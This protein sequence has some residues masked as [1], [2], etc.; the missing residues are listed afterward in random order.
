VDPESPQIATANA[1]RCA[2]CD[3]DFSRHHV[4]RIPPV[5]DETHEGA[6]EF[7]AQRTPMRPVTH[8]ASGHRLGKYELLE[9]IGQ[10]GMAEVWLGRCSVEHGSKTC[11]I[12]V[13][14][15]HIAY[16]TRYRQM[17][18]NEAR[19]CMK[20]TNANIV[21]VFDA[22]QHDTAL[23]L[24]MEWVDG[25]D[26]CS[27]LGMAR[28]LGC[29]VPLSVVGH[30]VGEL[31]HA[32]DYAH[33]L[34]SGGIPLGIVHRDVSPHNVMISTS[35]EVKLADF[36]VARLLPDESSHEYAKGKLRYMARE[37]LVGRPEPASDLFGVG[38]I[39]HELLSGERFRG[40]RSE[41]DLYADILGESMPVLDRADLPPDLER[42]RR[43]LLQP[44]V[45]H[46]LQT[47]SEALLVLDR[48]SGYRNARTQLRRLY[49][50]LFGAATPR[51]EVSGAIEPRA[52]RQP[53]E[54]LRVAV[55]PEASTHTHPNA[56]P[57]G[58]G[59]ES[60]SRPH[61]TTRAVPPPPKPTS[62][63]GER[64]GP[65]KP[66]ALPRRPGPW[67]GLALL[68]MLAVLMLWLG[69]GLEPSP[70][71][72]GAAAES[73]VVHWT[74]EGARG[75]WLRLDGRELRVDDAIELELAPGRHA[76]WWR[77]STDRAWKPGG[78]LV[79]P[80]GQRHVV[81]IRSDPDLRPEA[82]L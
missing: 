77:A 69:H 35:G 27:L 33:R 65:C 50:D 21:Q 51:S 19:L 78:Q 14:L 24:A 4:Q 15:P 58:Q 45:S 60:R 31:L 55:D 73:A 40:R 2:V 42:L 63:A 16:D 7:R 12:K 34:T 20:L 68:A 66:T 81:R 52:P 32:L 56:L 22:G 59:F 44:D 5:V 13:M 48:W 70:G 36:G 67:V 76:I 82:C 39:L 23:Y 26:L 10:G 30:V 71:S 64:S 61:G 49:E 17:F 79:L 57:R 72:H 25:T 54:V 41:Q 9:K 80:S 8:L 75:G 1:A 3:V 38:A 43:S 18:C 74:L 47:A 28:R 29:E 11:A 46:R 37:Q 62:P 6:A 53:T